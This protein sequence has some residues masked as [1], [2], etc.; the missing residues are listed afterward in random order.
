MPEHAAVF[1][2]G[3]Y[4]D[5]ILIEEYD[6]ARINYEVFSEYLCG[7]YKRWSTFYFHCPPWHKLSNWD[8]FVYSLQR[9]KR[10]EVRTGKLVMHDGELHQKGVDIRIAIDMVRLAATN[11]IEKAILVSGDSDLVPAV[12]AVQDCSVLVELV[13][14]KNSIGDHLYLTARDRTELTQAIIDACLR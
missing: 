9:L 1:I 10:F 6:K 4:L 13:Y 2:D 11:R 3:A 7:D 14:S 12:E 8:K 5:Y